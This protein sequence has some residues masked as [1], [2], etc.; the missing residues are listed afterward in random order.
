MKFQLMRS[1]DACE[2]Y[3][4]RFRGEIPESSSTAQL[5]STF[6]CGP[7]RTSTSGDPQGLARPSGR[8]RRVPIPVS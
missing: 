2:N 7:G 8:V 3:C 4:T 1:P 6:I 5:L